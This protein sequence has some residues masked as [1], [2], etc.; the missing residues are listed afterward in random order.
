MGDDHS[1]SLQKGTGKEIPVSI[2][3]TQIKT[4]V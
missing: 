3:I 4:K 1:P 2:F